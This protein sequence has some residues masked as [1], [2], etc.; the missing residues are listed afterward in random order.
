[1]LEEKS[2]S[3]MQMLKNIGEGKEYRFNKNSWNFINLNLENF[4]WKKTDN[5]VV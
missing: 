2:I 5:Y 3:V 4:V 1:M